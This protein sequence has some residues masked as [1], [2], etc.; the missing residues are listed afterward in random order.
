MT[1]RSK[2]SLCNALRYEVP[3]GEA[4]YEP[5]RSLS[6]SYRSFWYASDGPSDGLLAR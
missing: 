2:L 3:F 6:H 1:R 4:H 5:I